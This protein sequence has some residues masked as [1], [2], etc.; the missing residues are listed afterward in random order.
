MDALRMEEKRVVA[1]M[2]SKGAKWHCFF[3]DFSDILGEHHAGPHLHYLSHRWTTPGLTRESVW[4]AFDSRKNSL[5]RGQHIAYLDTRV[6]P[7]TRG[8]RFWMKGPPHVL[9][10]DRPGDVE[11]LDGKNESPASDSDTDGG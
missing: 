2:F 8:R 4:A 10:V 11:R 5:P 7:S 6:D 9:R 3:F 1:H